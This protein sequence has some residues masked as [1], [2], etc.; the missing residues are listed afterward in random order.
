MNTIHSSVPVVNL[1][2]PP[3]WAKHPLPHDDDLAAAEILLSRFS[4]GLR[5]SVEQGSISQLEA[6]RQIAEFK[7]A[8]Q[9]NPLEPDGLQQKQRK[10]PDPTEPGPDEQKHTALTRGN[11]EA[12]RKAAEALEALNS[13]AP[14]SSV[15]IPP[16]VII[17]PTLELFNE[18]R[19]EIGLKPLKRMPKRG[20]WR[21][22][23]FN[24]A[25]FSD[26][27]KE[28]A[29]AG[30][31]AAG[32]FELIP[33]AALVSP[34]AFVD[35]RWRI[36]YR[37]AFELRN[38]I[39]DRVICAESITDAIAFRQLDHE[40]QQAVDSTGTV[41]WH[42]W[43]EQTDTSLAFADST[44]PLE[45]CLQELA[46]LY[47]KRETAR[48]GAALADGS[49]E[50][51]DAK[52]ALEELLHGRNG[53]SQELPPLEA[54]DTFCS[55]PDDTPPEV[56]EGILHQGSKGELGGGSKTFKTW[57]LLHMASCV[58]TGTPWL[59]FKT[60]PGKV[61]YLNFELPRWSIRKR[62][63][64]I[65]NALETKHLGNLKLLNLRGYACDAHVILPRILQETRQ[66]AFVLIIIDPL[67]KILGDR[68][69]NASNDMADLML[70]IE[71]LAVDS[72]AAVV[73]GAHFSKGNQSLKEAMDRISGSGVLARDPD[74]IITM[75]D[76]EEDEAYTV[77]MI[78]RNFPPQKPFVL[79]RK[80]PLMSRTELD[81]ARLKKPKK[82]MQAVYSSDLLL[83]VLE[84]NG[85]H[86]PYNEWRDKCIE[87]VGFSKGTFYKLF[88]E[89]RDAK[90]IFCSKIDEKWG[91]KP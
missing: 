9:R 55:E 18:V 13:G 36:V 22:P 45:Y 58:S 3:Q 44:R 7:Q 79:Q 53:S 88:K 65:C 63:K 41:D 39:S 30:A 48:I 54:A 10:R 84:E 49:L 91:L 87:K 72:N 59:E 78:L 37:I 47:C 11:A 38:E 33:A 43:P 42:K 69:E 73:F 24:M 40:L 19:R 68:E 89:L 60:H 35:P 76:H 12:M 6:D 5:S 26:L 56:I 21:G 77:D 1:P 32:T 90:R 20:A 23:I 14:P 67:Y 16:G 8:L 50:L 27:S 85:G 31:I 51:A 17:D 62:V 82:G 83:E 2:L 46:H 80:H 4:A 86:L 28:S 57:T 61:L 34:E 64:E 70:A 75:T 81:P 25:R 74:T 29:V 71:R 15:E 52:I 66:H